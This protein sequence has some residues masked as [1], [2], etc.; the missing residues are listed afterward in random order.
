M[1]VDKVHHIREHLGHV[2]HDTGHDMEPFTHP[3]RRIIGVCNARI[4]RL[5]VFLLNAASLIATVVAC[6]M[7]V[8]Q[9]VE[10]D[11]AW[12]ALASLGILMAASAVFVGLNEGF[13][14]AIRG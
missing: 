1:Q 5:L 13:G 3:A 14:P 10:P 11:V 4:T 7:A 9:Y 2:G 8:W 6:L 12:R